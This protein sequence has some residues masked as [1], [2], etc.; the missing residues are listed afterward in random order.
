[1]VIDNGSTDGTR[2]MMARDYPDLVYEWLPE[3]AGTRA[4]NLGLENAT[5]DAFWVSNNDSYPEG[6]DALARAAAV[7]EKHPDIHVI[8][9]EN[10]E[11]GDGGRIYQWHPLPVPKDAEPEGG[12]PTNLFHGTGAAIR[13]EVIETIGG[14]WDVFGYEELDFCTRAIAAGFH[15]RY[16][17]SIRTLHFNSPKSRVLTDRWVGAATH[18]MRYVWRHLPLGEALYRTAFYYP[19][20]LLQG[21]SYPARPRE[22]LA[23]L[24]GMPRTAIRTF[25][26]ERRVIPRGKLREV[27]LGLG[28]LAVTWP[29]V[30]QALK[31]RVRRLR[32]PR[33]PAAGA[34]SGSSSHP[35]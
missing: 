12:F 23:V 35:G 27:T 7:F 10:L 1:V 8:G 13:R 14:F 34:P 26:T 3:N 22:F 31:R 6:K 33:S 9:T 15:V 5:G 24:I 29:F 17:P 32:S 25:R 18:M 11:M 30:V 19:Y 28:P 20:F 2:E 21:F 4:I 16:I